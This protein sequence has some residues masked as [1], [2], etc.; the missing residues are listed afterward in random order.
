MTFQEHAAACDG[1]YRNQT[2]EFI[3][4]GDASRHVA[5]MLIKVLGCLNPFQ[6]LDAIDDLSPRAGQAGQVQPARVLKLGKFDPVD[7]Y[8][9]RPNPAREPLKD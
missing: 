7:L 4:T 6:V 3:A 1:L 5:K 2:R 9:P 8:A